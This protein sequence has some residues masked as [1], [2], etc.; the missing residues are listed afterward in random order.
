M[1]AVR[2]GLI[3]LIAILG[4]AFAWLAFEWSRSDA[5]PGGGPF[6]VTFE[7]VDQTGAPIT[8]AAFQEK[9]TALFFG[10]THCPEVCPTTLFEMDAWLRQVDPEGDKI[11]AYFITVDPERDNEEVL[12]A[13]VSSVSDRIVGI[14]GEPAKVRD[15]ARGYRVFFEKVPTDTSDP[16]GDY[17]MNHTASVFLLADGGRFQGTIAYGEDTDVAVSKL[18]NLISG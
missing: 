17:T 11:N 2:T 18:Q 9:P 10:F 5:G 12:D 6:G 14:T 1:A 8:Q 7:L 4:V 16:D 15:M 13:Y 3:V